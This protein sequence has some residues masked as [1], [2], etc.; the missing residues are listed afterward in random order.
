MNPDARLNFYRNA[1]GAKFSERIHAAGAVVS[2]STMVHS[3]Q[4]LV[5][6]GASQINNSGV[7]TRLHCTDASHL[8]E[9]SLRLNLVATWR[10]AHV[11]TDAERAAL[12]LAE[13][14]TRI[15]DTNGVVPDEVWDNAAKHHDPDQLAALVAQ[16]ALINIFNRISLITR[17]P[18]GD[19]EPGRWNPHTRAAYPHRE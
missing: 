16:I 5:R 11:F 18:D 1:I 12:E 4:E 19:Y 10:D 2:D 17:Q 14:G 8:G 7:C 6:I 9:T 13:C 3:T 15:A